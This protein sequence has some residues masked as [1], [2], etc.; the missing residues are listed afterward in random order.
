M[1]G[2]YWLLIAAI[3]GAII[4]AATPAILHYRGSREAPGL[5]WMKKKE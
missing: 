5:K 4:S 1:A 3:A 2:L